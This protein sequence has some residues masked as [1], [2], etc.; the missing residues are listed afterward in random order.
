[1]RGAHVVLVAPVQPVRIIPADA[2]STGQY[3]AG[4]VTVMDHPRRCGEHPQAK[5]MIK[6][7]Q[8]S[9]PQ[10]RG[11]LTP[12]TCAI[13]G[14]RII[15]ADAGSTGETLTVTCDYGDHP[16]RCGEHTGEWRNTMNRYGS[17]PQMRGALITLSLSLVS[18]RIIPADAGS[19]A[20]NAA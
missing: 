19:T 1:M 3:K 14:T 15:P 17:S 16:R 5:Q 7:E 18:E 11:A 9:S 20:L 6:G 2:G 13:M 4:A 8:G 10:M 12:L